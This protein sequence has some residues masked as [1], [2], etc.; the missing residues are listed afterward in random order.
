M[1]TINGEAVFF[2]KGTGDSMKNVMIE[3][4]KYN[5]EEGIKYE[6]NAHNQYL[7][8]L[9]SNGLIGL[10]FF[11][12]IIILPL[13]YSLKESDILSISILLLLI[14]FSLTESILERHSGVVL[15]ALFTSLIYYKNKKI[16]D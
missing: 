12:M 1:N 3:Y 6:Y 15:F 9:S 10:G 16:N 13:I 7:E 5:F 2:G 8:I 4:E 11:L 14:I